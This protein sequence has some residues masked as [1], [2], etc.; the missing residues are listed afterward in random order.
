M[1]PP[2]LVRTF[3]ADKGG[4]GALATG[5]DALDAELRGGFPRAAVTEIVSDYGHGGDWLA[6]RAL[7]HCGGDCAVLDSDESFFPPG[8]AAAGVDLSRLLIV[9]EKNV[10]QARWA[11][12]RLV[13]EPKLRATF[14]WL[15][16][17]SD[18]LLRR[19]QLAA[20][21]SGNSLILLRR[22]ARGATWGALRLRVRGLP[23]DEGRTLMVETLRA[24]G[25]LMPRPVK[26]E[27]DD[28]ALS[29][30]MAAVLPHGAG[31]AQRARA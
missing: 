19:L 31:D 7:A 13:R 10:A 11:L 22:E 29:V 3:G 8:A 26:I 24:R 17:L 2:E 1:L 27:V 25:G 23:V 16:G 15:E 20:E 14:A 6:L 12:E 5:I 30:R 9:R 21:R 28:G 18:T 4:A